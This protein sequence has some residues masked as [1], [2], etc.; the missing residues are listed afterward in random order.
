M[1]TTQNIT[2]MVCKQWAKEEATYL[3]DLKTEPTESSLGLDYVAALEA[4]AAAE[5]AYEAS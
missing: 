1:A 2:N 4:L 5:L 3:A